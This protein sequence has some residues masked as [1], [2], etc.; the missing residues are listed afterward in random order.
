MNEVFTMTYE[1]F[2]AEEPAAIVAVMA[3]PAKLSC[4]DCGA[5]MELKPSRY[6]QF[7]GCSTW[8]ETKCP[9]SHG[10]HPDGRPLGI[11]ASKATKEARMRAHE[12][13]DRLWKS[14]AMARGQAYVW[15]QQALGM[16]ADDA[17]IARFSIEQCDSLISAVEL[18][19]ASVVSKG[20]D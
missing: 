2:D 16:G 18:Y 4:P 8:R 14:G 1:V 13:F 15:M 6:G 7:Y 5:A 10:A 20:T 12:C 3:T 9:G 11:P 17:H 19:L